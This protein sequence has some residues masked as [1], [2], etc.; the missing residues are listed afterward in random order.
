[1]V[2]ATPRQIKKHKPNPKT[3]CLQLPSCGAVETT[4][5]TQIEKRRESNAEKQ[6][7]AGKVFR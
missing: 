6:K 2:A 5:P 1:M 3:N 7:L 4:I